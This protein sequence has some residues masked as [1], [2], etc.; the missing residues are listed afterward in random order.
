MGDNILVEVDM[1]IISATIALTD[2]MRYISSVLNS[3][4]I[5]INNDV[6]LSSSL[7]WK[8]F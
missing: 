5:L 1:L 4:F 6:L 2:I 8:F 3:S 7:F